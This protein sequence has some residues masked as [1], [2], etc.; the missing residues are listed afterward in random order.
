MHTPLRWV[1]VLSAMRPRLPLARTARPRVLK[2]RQPTAWYPL[3][4]QVGY[5]T[6]HPCPMPPHDSGHSSTVICADTLARILTPRHCCHDESCRRHSHSAIAIA[7]FNSPRMLSPLLL[8]CPRKPAVFSW[9]VMLLACQTTQAVLRGQDARGQAAAAEMLQSRPP[10]AP[11]ATSL[12][13]PRARLQHSCAS[14]TDACQRCS[15]ARCLQTSSARLLGSQRWCTIGWFARSHPRHI[16]IVQNWVIGT[17]NPPWCSTACRRRRCRSLA[18]WCPR[19]RG[20]RTPPHL[21]LWRCPGM[22]PRQSTPAQAP[23]CLPS[24]TASPTQY[25]CVEQNAICSKYAG[26]AVMHAIQGFQ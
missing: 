23:L 15:K 12:L 6:P 3:P 4:H 26:R 22:H 10:N 16:N 19:A 1:N 25:H 17:K 2:T 13:I 11:K 21:Q 20:C 8:T 18:A 7:R 5:C 14:K 24:C 9:S